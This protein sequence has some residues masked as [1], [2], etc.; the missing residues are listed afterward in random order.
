MSSVIGIDLGTTYSCVAL[1][2]NNGVT[3]LANKMGN[4]TTPSVVAYTDTDRLIGILFITLGEAARNQAARNPKRTI[5]D[6]KRMIGR[7]LRDVEEY[8]F[9]IIHFSLFGL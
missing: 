2:E 5:F 9:E 1:W 6:A 3:V 8:R 4:R 7:R